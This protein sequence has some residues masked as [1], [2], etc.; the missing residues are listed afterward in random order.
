KGAWL[1]F[2]GEL[3]GQGKDAAQKA[4]AEKPD[5]AK[6]IIAA[7]LAKRNGTS[8]IAAAA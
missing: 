4:L 8:A 6:K 2:E 7:I 1:Q 3:I 5:L